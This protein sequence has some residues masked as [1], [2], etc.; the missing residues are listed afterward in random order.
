M[1]ETLPLNTPTTLKARLSL[2]WKITIGLISLLLI[3]TIGIAWYGT[4]QY[5]ELLRKDE[6][7][8]AQW[9]HV[10][11]QYTRRADLIPNLVTVVKTYAS[12]ET[13]LFKEIAVARSRVNSL[14]TAA[15]N[16]R[17]P[18]AVEQ[19]QK[20][21]NQLAAPLA[22]L[23]VIAENYPQLK[24]DSLF[25]DLMVQLEGTENRIAYA[26]QRYI[27]SV[28]DYNFDI[29]RFPNNLVALLAGYQT[30]ARF[31]V[32]NESVLSKS[33]QLDMK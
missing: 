17:D 7:V 4:Q 13:E 10:L 9:S 6:G 31:K 3:V 21:Q 14:S 19:F 32:E 12:H 20:A 1:D 11:N 5:N 30:R 22:R 26:R 29:R 33:P 15:E 16:S 18:Q 8:E 27:E 28:A 25:R 2:F 23:L 24:A